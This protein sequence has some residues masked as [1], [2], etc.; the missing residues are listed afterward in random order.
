[1]KRSFILLISLILFTISSQQSTFTQQSI[2]QNIYK[3]IL[4]INGMTFKKITT[5]LAGLYG[6]AQKLERYYDDNNKIRLIR[7]Y[8]TDGS[9]TRTIYYNDKGHIIFSSFSY[10]ILKNLYPASPYTVGQVFG[11]GYYHDKRLISSSSQYLIFMKK[12]F[13]KSEAQSEIRVHLKYNNITT[14]IPNDKLSSDKPNP[15]SVKFRSPINRDK[16]YILFNNTTLRSGPGTQYKN[17]KLLPATQSV[18]IISSGNY[19]NIGYLRYHRWYKVRYLVEYHAKSPDDV[20]PKIDNKKQYVTGWVFGALISP[21][22]VE[23][24]E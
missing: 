12:H 3:Q 9:V 14:Y 16:T 6:L 22:D 21:I 8:D 5:Q 2:E 15:K 18:E 11:H 1:M 19:Q 10:Y 4:K 24:S 7:Y 23:M 17:L 13:T 20:T